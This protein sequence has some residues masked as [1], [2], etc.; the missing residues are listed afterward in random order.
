[1]RTS[2]MLEKG[3]IKGHQLSGMLPEQMLEPAPEI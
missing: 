2:Q 3:S 1:M